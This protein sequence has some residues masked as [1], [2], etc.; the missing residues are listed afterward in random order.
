MEISISFIGDKNK[1]NLLIHRYITMGGFRLS[2]NLLYTL[3]L[4]LSIGI[5]IWEIPICQKHS[6]V[7]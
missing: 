1:F 7:S 5:Q 6:H 3:V 2:F 4:L